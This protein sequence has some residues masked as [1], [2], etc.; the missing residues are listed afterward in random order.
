VLSIELIALSLR[1]LHHLS[2]APRVMDHVFIR[3]Q[4]GERHVGILLFLQPLLTLTLFHNRTLLK[5]AE[6]GEWKSYSGQ[7]SFEINKDKEP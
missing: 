7:G 5:M 1:L 6:G 3:H 4:S 2:H